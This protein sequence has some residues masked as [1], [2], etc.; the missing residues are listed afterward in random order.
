[1]KN[2]N[3]KNKIEFKKQ[4]ENQ[5]KSKKNINNR[6]PSQLTATKKKH[7]TENKKKKQRKK[8]FIQK[9][10]PAASPDIEKSEVFKLLELT[11]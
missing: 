5:K 8:E 3:S 11:T 4:T 1:L 10:T 2:E 6:L 7:K 9:N